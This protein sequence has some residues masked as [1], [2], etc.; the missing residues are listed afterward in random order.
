MASDTA[1]A[2]GAGSKTGINGWLAPVGVFPGQEPGRCQPSGFDSSTHIR[3]SRADRAAA[4][5]R[6]VGLKD[7][8]EQISRAEDDRNGD[9][10][11]DYLPEHMFGSVMR[12][13]QAY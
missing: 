13:E 3:F 8:P 4:S 5:V 10:E 12:V 1:E 11:H 9:D 7:L 2:T 6:Q